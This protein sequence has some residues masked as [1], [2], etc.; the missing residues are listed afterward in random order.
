MPVGLRQLLPLAAFALV[1]GSP[2]AAPAQTIIDEWSSI[3][4]PPAPE[5]KPVTV[6]PSTTALLM[7]DFVKQTCN[8][9]RRPRCVASL[10]KVKTL[11]DEARA[12]N[13]LMV[14]SVISDSTVGDVLPAVAPTA[15]E[16]VVSR[17]S[18]SSPRPISNRSSRIRTS[19]R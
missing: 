14:Y 18:T 13:M 2:I 7:L 8:E 10:P 11:L 1:L 5:L 3:K 9:Q 15:N 17:G 19:R 16:P 12:K 6:D 4:A